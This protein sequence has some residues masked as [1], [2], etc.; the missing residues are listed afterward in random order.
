MKTCTVDGCGREVWAR[1]WCMAHY[2]RWKRHGDVRADVPL[3]RKKGPPPSG[4]CTVKGCDRP[5]TT[6][7]LC[8]AH[9]MR[10]NTHG[11]VM[12]EVPIRRQAPRGGQVCS[13][14]GCEAEAIAHGMCGK[15]SIRLNRHGD[16]RVVVK[17]GPLTESDVMLIR[18][19]R[20]MSGKRGVQK[21]LAKRF[22]V[23]HASISHIVLGKSW[24]HLPVLES[25]AAGAAGRET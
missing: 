18:W 10:L 2:S 17:H 11:R 13:V 8:A 7:G 5:Q 25:N 21:A 22:G 24:K 15:H 12:A 9:Y 23:T 3:L 19:L 14:A 20:W 16:H 4:T 1:G 6:R